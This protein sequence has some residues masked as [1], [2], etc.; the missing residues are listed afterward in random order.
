MAL[1]EVRLALVAM[2]MVRLA[3]VVAPLAHLTLPSPQ[4]TVAA[5]PQADLTPASLQAAAVAPPEQAGLGAW[6]QPVVQ[7]ES[8]ASVASPEAASVV[9]A[10]A[11]WAA[12]TMPECRMPRVLS[13]VAR[14]DLSEGRQQEEGQR[15]AAPAV[16]ATLRWTAERHHQAVVVWPRPAGRRETRVAA[17]ACWFPVEHSIGAT[18]EWTIRTW[19]TQRR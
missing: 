5:P 14:A 6:V 7:E 12:V 13:Q 9:A 10:A 17:Q 19:A 15:A 16:V 2:G 4:A 1:S 3:Q 11:G 18:T 8:V